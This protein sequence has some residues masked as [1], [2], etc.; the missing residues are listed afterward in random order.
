[1]PGALSVLLKAFR[2]APEKRRTSTSDQT[3]MVAAMMPGQAEGSDSA[4]GTTMI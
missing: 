3:E 1:M 2:R 4:A